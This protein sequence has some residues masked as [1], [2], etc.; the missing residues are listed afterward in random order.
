LTEEHFRSG[1]INFLLE[2]RKKID[3]SI[4]VILGV[5]GADH[6]GLA[7]FIQITIPSLRQ[8]KEDLPFIF[9]AYLEEYAARYNKQI[10]CISTELIQLLSAG[11]FAGNYREI[12]KITETAVLSSKSDR[13]EVKDFPLD[14][15]SLIQSNLKKITERELPLADA[16][17][18]FENKLYSHL[19]NKANND[20]SVLARFLDTPRNVLTQRIEDLQY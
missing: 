20:T 13:L 12:E 15:A 19:L 3:K 14:L 10:A 2:R 18:E 11:E 5:S 17:R 16:K 8:R 7:D 6:S 9:N 4:R 1:L